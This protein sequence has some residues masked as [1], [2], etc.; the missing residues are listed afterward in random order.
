MVDAA[1]QKMLTLY[2]GA[3]VGRYRDGKSMVGMLIVSS[4]L[5]SDNLFCPNMRW[6]FRN[7]RLR[8]VIEIMFQGLLAGT[9]GIAWS[10]LLSTLGEHR[11]QQRGYLHLSNIQTHSGWAVGDFLA[12]QTRT[13]A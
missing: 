9:A 2:V 11:W 1:G 3:V 6:I 7:R 13:I 12:V 8:L 5:M 10:P 4:R